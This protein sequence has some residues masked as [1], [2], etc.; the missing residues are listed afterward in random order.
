M[1]DGTPFEPTIWMPIAEQAERDLAAV[2]EELAQLV[3]S[4]DI[5]WRSA[6]RRMALLR[7]RGHEPGYYVWEA[8]QQVWQASTDADAIRE[9][10][11]ISADPLLEPLQR[12]SMLNTRT[13]RYGVTY[14]EQHVLPD[15]RLH[16]GYRAIGA[17]TGRA[18]CTEPNLLQ[19]PRE[20]PGSA[21]RQA[22]RPADGRGIVHADFSQVQLRIGADQSGDLALIREYARGK[23]ADVHTLTASRMFNI[24]LEQVTRAQRQ[25]GKTVNL[26]L[27]FGAGPARLR[28]TLLKGGELIS[29]DAAKR[30]H[31]AF[32]IA[33]PGLA[34]WPKSFDDGPVSLRTA[35]GRRR[36]NVSRYSERPNSMAQMTESDSM[37]RALALLAERW[38]R[39]MPRSAKLVL[40]IYDEVKVECD[41][42]D[43]EQVAAV[44][45]DVM[46]EGMQ[47]QLERVPVEVDITVGQDW[48]GTP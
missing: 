41:R 10:R 35:T 1:L 5:N 43:A 21:Y 28:R 27:E 22:F 24:P 3:D 40:L 44:L 29:L 6:P 14:P 36:L 48:A 13:T 4:T 46:V 38:N 33:Y 32:Q 34:H 47:S 45:H 9:L 31:V 15:G 11:L 42:A 19:I 2:S 17:A 26:A 39:D 37:K 25:I 18:T 30:R 23:D 8:G 7:E 20:G 16:G 12:W